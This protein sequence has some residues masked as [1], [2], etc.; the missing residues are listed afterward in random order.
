MSVHAAITNASPTDSLTRGLVGYWTFDGP[1]MISKVKDKSGRGNDAILGGFA[2][3]TSTYVVPGRVGQALNFKGATQNNYASTTVAD[4]NFERTDTFSMS[5]WIKTDGNFPSGCAS[6]IV[7][8]SKYV[9]NDIGYFFYVIGPNCWPGA[10]YENTLSLQ[11]WSTGSC[12]GALIIYS[13]LGAITPN[14]WKHVLVTYDGSGDLSGVKMYIDGV[15]QSLTKY[16]TCTITVGTMKTNQPMRIGDD[17]T[18]D[19]FS[20]SLDEV[21]VYNRVLSATEAKQLY[22]TTAGAKIN[23]PVAGPNLTSGLVGWWTFDGNNMLSNVKDSSGQGNNGFMSGF[24][25]TS[26]AVVAGKVGQ[27]LK[28]DGVDD[29]VSIPYTGLDFERTDAFSFSV[30]AKIGST[31]PAPSTWQT[32]IGRS[33]AA[34][35]GTYFA[36]TQNTVALGSNA[37]AVNFSL[38]N[39]S[40]NAMVVS[41]AVGSFSPYYDKWT[42]VT[43]TYDGSSNVSGVK[44]YLN[45]VSFPV[46]SLFSTLSATIKPNVNWRIGDDYTNDWTR[47]SIDDVRIYNRVLSATEVQK[48]YNT[49]VGAK[50]NAPVAGPNLTSGLV[51]WWTFDGNNMF[52]NVKDSSGQGNNGIMS[53]FTSTSSAVVPG[54]LGQGLKFDGVDDKINAGSASSLDDIAT[55]N[56]SFTASLWVKLTGFGGGG[57]GMLLSKETNSLGGSGWYFGLISSFSS[58]RLVGRFNGGTNLEVR[59]ST[60]SFTAATDMGKWRHLVVTWDGSSTA[61]NV[62]IYKD[63]VELG[64]GA[65]IDGVGTFSSDAAR[66]FT[67]GGGDGTTGVLSDGVIDDV[68]V[69]NRTLSVSEIRRLYNMGR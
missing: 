48:L 45:G 59:T 51:G 19:Y 55:T 27:G 1:D 41:T 5:A 68:R 49:T 16:L 28:F 24:T 17:Y 31:F 64:Y 60:N 9:G 12:A 69:Y 42:L 8:N 39:I 61:S 11:L 66:S 35:K 26:S 14:I 63:G 67:I 33:G 10:S 22:N 47:G 58:L 43:V 13:P 36:V 65:Q 6:S 57:T 21:R 38:Y 34:N 15:S 56:G 54:K 29:Y 44:I 7:G 46:S 3:G 18:N 25:S 23:A 50:I 40:S 30:W 37:N 52:S 20:G 2:Q 53:G 32:F 62:H 4:F